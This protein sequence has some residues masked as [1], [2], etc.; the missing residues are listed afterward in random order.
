MVSK[1]FS[2]YHITKI[3]RG[4]FYSKIPKLY[5]QGF[6]SNSQNITPEKTAGIY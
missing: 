5:L 6:S 2:K 1:R 3:K 4:N